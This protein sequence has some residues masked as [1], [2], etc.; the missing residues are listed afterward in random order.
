MADIKIPNDAMALL[1]EIE[2][3]TFIGGGKLVRKSVA[4]DLLKRRGLISSRPPNSITGMSAISGHGHRWTV[5]EAGSQ[6]LC[7][8]AGAGPT[9][10]L[11]PQV[12]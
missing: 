11:P 8:T 1:R 5:T 2:R 12:G 10:I 9:R 7:V 6:A 3:A 4:R